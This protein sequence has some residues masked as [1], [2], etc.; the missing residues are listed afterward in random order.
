[1]P[2]DRYDPLVQTSAGIGSALSGAMVRE[3]RRAAWRQAALLALL[4]TVAAVAVTSATAGGLVTAQASTRSAC[5]EER[6]RAGLGRGAVLRALEAPER[7]R[8]FLYRVTSEPTG[9]R[10]Q[11]VVKDGAFLGDTWEQD[12]FGRLRHL[13]DV[14]RDRFTDEVGAR[15][16]AHL[17]T[18][19]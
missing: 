11:L 19:R 7:Q 2:P 15:L 10:V 16:L 3:Q 12:A 1:M 6:D 9:Y 4:L 18:P 17:E 8:R 5:E 13:H 14:C